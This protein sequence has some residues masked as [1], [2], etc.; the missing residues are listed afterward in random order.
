M[1]TYGKITNC[2]LAMKYLQSLSLVDD[3][4]YNCLEV[5]K[6]AKIQ[7]V[8]AIF[9]DLHK[10]AGRRKRVSAN[11]DYPPIFNR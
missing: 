6:S 9:L 5:C 1:V 11:M 2:P 4:A 8:W 3:F 10:R 7:D